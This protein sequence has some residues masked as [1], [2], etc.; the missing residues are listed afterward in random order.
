MTL[1]I[2]IPGLFENEAAKHE[3]LINVYAIRKKFEI[4]SAIMFRSPA[5]N[6][7]TIIIALA[8]STHQ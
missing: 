5:E 3:K 8:V 6:T 4:M 7:N 1:L 2:I